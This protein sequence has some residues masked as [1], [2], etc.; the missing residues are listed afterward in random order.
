MTKYNEPQLR[1]VTIVI[2]STHE[3][4][5]IEDKKSIGV[6]YPVSNVYRLD[7][8]TKDD[9]DI[10]LFIDYIKAYSQVMNCSALRDQ[11]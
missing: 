6:S 4:T 11:S 10:E 8:D 2:A 5:V 3:S 1:D 9:I 7:L